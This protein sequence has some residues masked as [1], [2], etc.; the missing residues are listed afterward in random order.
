MSSF[1]SALEVERIKIFHQ[2]SGPSLRIEHKQNGYFICSPSNAE[3][4][5]P[6]DR[7]L[8][9]RLVDAAAQPPLEYLDISR[10]G[11]TQEELNSRALQAYEARKE[12]LGSEYT[13]ARCEPPEC[14]GSLYKEAFIKSYT[15]LEEVDYQLKR[16]YYHIR[17][18][19]HSTLGFSA[20]LTFRNGET[21]RLSSFDQRHFL[22]PWTVQRSGKRF[23]TYSPDIARA[24]YDLFQEV[25][26]I[27][28]WL[29]G[30][31]YKLWANDFM[32]YPV[33][34]YISTA[35]A[36]Q[37]L[38][39]KTK[40]IESQF[41]I[42]GMSIHDR[43]EMGLFKLGGQWEKKGMLPKVRIV[44]DYD[45][46]IVKTDNV[47]ELVQKTNARIQRILDI[48]WFR[49]WLEENKSNIDH[50]RIDVFHEG[51]HYHSLEWPL[52]LL[53]VNKFDTWKSKIEKQRK[54]LVPITIEHEPLPTKGYGKFSKLLLFPNGEMILW[55]TNME[56][57]HTWNESKYGFQFSKD[58][59]RRGRDDGFINQVV[60]F[61]VQGNV[62]VD[63]RDPSTPC[64]FPPPFKKH[65]IY[66]DCLKK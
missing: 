7:S 21:W 60:H 52:L 36:S 59:S 66:A 33:T 6:V 44:I 39:E 63:Y 22:L 61:D 38:G 19:D 20:T 16:Y 42:L 54:E 35:K 49:D 5:K 37:A 34:R 58:R 64:Y 10:L 31:L 57:L 50:W 3:K 13:P 51:E 18:A 15:N 28:D 48:K 43:N 26:I 30:D 2:Y 11:I 25:H 14:S 8:V 41:K 32:Y 56:Q 17:M 9:Q 55:H 12:G 4:C 62:T 27:P 40:I 45:I 65:Y 23:E 47:A 1:T 46:N 53:K 24:I 29:I